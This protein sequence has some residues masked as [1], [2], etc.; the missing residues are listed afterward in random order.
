MAKIGFKK[1]RGQLV[2]DIRWPDRLRSRIRVHSK[3]EATKKQLALKLAFLNGTWEALRAQMLTEEPVQDFKVASFAAMVEDYYEHW[4]KPRN[5]AWKSKLTHLNR[6]KSRFR[7]VPPRAFRA[8][9]AQS[10][11]VWRLAAGIKNSTVNKE[12]TTLKHLFSW[13]AKMGYVEK[14]PVALVEKLYQP[15]WSGPKP[16]DEAIESVLALLHP[17]QRAVC[18]VLRE[19]GA[20]RGEIFN[21]KHW[22]IDRAAKTILI[23]QSKTGRA[24]V[25]PLTKKA[26]EAIDSIPPLHGC[27]YVFYNPETGTCW[28]DFKRQWNRAREAAGYPWLRIRDLRPAF[29]I[30]AAELGAPMHF[31]QSALGHTSVQITERY[32]AKFDKN[33][34]AK[35]LLK[36]IETG[37]ATGT[38]GKQA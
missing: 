32:Y 8:S 5:R 3:D 26:L 16:T 10:Y 38:D 12:M 37:E 23:N 29:A 9:H 14:S 35:A 19:T 33:S 27:D 2:L 30:N 24:T 7:S 28:K 34:A 31:I 1:F 22:Q 17:A 21:L 20:R 36:L 13:G 18:V 6:F 25:A 4:V 15:E 11:I